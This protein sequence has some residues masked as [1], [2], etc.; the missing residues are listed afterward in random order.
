MVLFG[1]PAAFSPACSGTH[2]ALASECRPVC[3]LPARRA[4]AAPV[5]GPASIDAR[6]LT[7]ARHARIGRGWAASDPRIMDSE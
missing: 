7:A 6:P 3:R 2:A 4:R 5:L 1:V